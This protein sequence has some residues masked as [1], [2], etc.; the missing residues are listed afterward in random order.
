MQLIFRFSMKKTILLFSIWAFLAPWAFAQT[1]NDGPIELQV[2]LREVNTTFNQTDVQLFGLVG[3]PDDLTYFVWARDNGDVDGLGWQGGACL[4]DDFNPPGISTDFDYTLINNT[5]PAST[6]PQ[7]FDLKVDAWEDDSDDTACSGS[8]CSY[9]TNICCGVMVLGACIGIT[10]DD[11]N[12]CDADPFKTQV[13]Y[14]LGPPCQW[15]DHGFVVGNCPSNNYYQPHIQSYWRYTK[16]TNCA[17]SIDLGTLSPA[18]SVSHFNSNECYANNWSA[19]PGNDVFYE[20]TITQPMGLT[21]SLCAGA[22]FNTNLYLL[23]NTCTTQLAFN[24]NFCAQTSEISTSICNPGTYIVVVDGNGAADM[25]TFTLTISDNP[26]VLVEANAGPPNVSLC[27]GDSIMLGGSPAAFN[28]FPPYT[29]AWTPAT[30]LSGTN[31]PNPMAGPLATTSY[32]LTVTD[33]T[34]CM[35]TD[36]ITVTVDPIPTAG[37]SATANLICT[38][39]SALLTGTGGLSYQ[40]LFNNGPIPAATGATYGATLPGNYSVVAINSFGCTDTSGIE[41]ISVVSQAIA[42]ASTPGPTTICA[43]DS[44]NLFA[45][46]VG[47]NYQWTLN[48]ALIPGATNL[49]YTAVS[50][51]NYQVIM[52]FGGNCPDTSSVIPVTVNTN[53]VG[54]IL[55]SGAAAICQGGSLLLQAS[56]GNSYQWIYN[57]SQLP[58]ATSTTYTASMAGNYYAIVTSS[59]GCRDT[60]QTLMLTVNPKPAAFATAMGPTTFCA[61]TSVTLNALGTGTFQWL[62]NNL[63]IGGASGAT[64]VA[65]SSGNYAVVVTSGVGCKD[66]SNLIT[67]VVNPNPNATIMATGPT[68]ICQGNSA[69]LQ[70]SGGTSYQWLLSGAIIPGA[71]AA[72]YAAVL[73][74]PYSVVATNSSGCRDTSSIMNITVQPQ[75]VASAIATTPTSICAGDTVILAASGGG[76]YQWLMNGN[77]IGG[78]TNAILYATGAGNYRVVVRNALGTCPDTSAAISITLNPQPV[79]NISANG[80]ASFCAG[81]SVQLEGN[82]GML[83][84]WMYNGLVVP[85][86]TDSI[87]TALAAGN[88]AVIVSNIFGCRDTS[89]AVPVTLFPQPIASVLPLGSTTVCAGDTAT[90]IASGGG[91]Y[92]WLLNGIPL[93]GATNAVYQTM[94]PGSY[95]VIVRN[96]MSGCPDTSSITTVIVNPL[97]SPGIAPINASVCPASNQVFTASGGTNYQWLLNGSPIPGATGGSFTTNI[98]GIYSVIA[99]SAAGCTQ[100][101]QN[102]TLSIYPSPVAQIASSGS[103]TICSGEPLT[104]F[105]AGGLVYQWQ[106]NGGNISGANGGSL[107][108]FASGSYTV[109]ATSANGCKDTSAAVTV[110]IRPR[111]LADISPSGNVEICAGGAATLNGIGGTTYQWLFNNVPVPGATAGLFSAMDPGL[112]SVVALNMF[113]CKDTSVI[114][115]LSLAS[116]PAAD[117][118][119]MGPTTVCTGET[120]PLLGFGTGDYQWLFNGNPLPGE[121][122][123]ML[124]VSGS[125]EYSV[126]VSNACGA[127]TSA[128]IGVMIN[129]DPVAGFLTEPAEPAAGQSFVFVDQ[130]ISAA[131]WSWDFG[132]GTGNSTLQNP[133]YSFSETGTYNVTLAITDDTGC[134]DTIT[135]S[136]F[137]KPFGDIFIPN[138]FTPNGDGF[139]DRFEIY[140]SDYVEIDLSIFDRWGKEVFRTTDPGNFWDGTINGGSQANEGVYYYVI[141]ASKEQEEPVYFNGNLTL[142][143]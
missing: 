143:R 40:W 32:T 128:E 141:K 96:N 100:Q 8:R 60:T 83:Y 68:T 121:T 18:A 27:I 111:P 41:S 37:I 16:G 127:D 25:G 129:P 97:P 74:G 49:N 19:S 118:M 80:P 130:S 9:E 117:I 126:E 72:T 132:D 65:N 77:P 109:I 12:H 124:T 64:Y 11:D 1:Y 17:N 58:G 29:Y 47:I 3:S 55:P 86:A 36:M 114:T 88:Y 103:T 23:D 56:G 2:K 98:G 76:L 135:L 138:V 62:K 122:T 57:G 139:V 28:G 51:G 106:L 85:G 53:P 112:Y 105:G 131:T 123:S 82:G 4:T 102:A 45:S 10:T 6:V 120:V 134:P 73:P 119:A 116:A 38:G 26:T 5:Y 43:G 22:T 69:N 59:A 31:I 87:L 79:A 81:D 142:I 39:T 71:T 52:S 15:F 92:Q 50:P 91:Q 89:A 34:G 54:N 113:G 46:G 21:I 140:Y 20:F 33:N 35:R 67:I 136:I 61:G 90:L 115:T 101:S 48:G 107:E 94:L 75:A 84:Q 110:T 66:T 125:G 99:I 104:L 108:P 44:V 42:I 70:A 63:L 95:S 24:N 14:R 93:P 137:I 7:Y 30:G 133:V 78:A 13:D